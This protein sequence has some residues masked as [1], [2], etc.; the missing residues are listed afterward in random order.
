M[1]GGP[2]GGGFELDPLIGLDDVRKPLRS[3]LLA[4]PQYRERYLRNVRELAEKSLDWNSLGPVVA[5]YRELIDQEVRRDTRKLS[6]YDA[7]AR[8]TADRPEASGEGRGRD[9]PLRTFA[10]QRRTYLLNSPEI[11]QLAR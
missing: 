11:K 6:T 8:A 3:K 4:V 7:F 10:E 5:Q 9:V 1:A 2:R